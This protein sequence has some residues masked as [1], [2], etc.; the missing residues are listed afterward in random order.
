MNIML[1]GK[2]L[3]VVL[4]HIDGTVIGLGAVMHDQGLHRFGGDLH[5]GLT[6]IHGLLNR[7]ACHSSQKA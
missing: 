7:E 6:V 3:R 5:R 1:C 2:I 4:Q